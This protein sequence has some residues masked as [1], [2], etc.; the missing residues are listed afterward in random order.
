MRV[1][2]LMALPALASGC[3]YGLRTASNT[4]R[5]A[6]VYRVGKQEAP[7]GGAKGA[8]TQEPLPDYVEVAQ[9]EWMLRA[10]CL[11]TGADGKV[12]AIAGCTPS[13]QSPQSLWQEAEAEAAR[14]AYVE[15]SYSETRFVP[16]VQG[17]LEFTGPGAATQS[18]DL[19]PKVVLSAAD[20]EAKGEADVTKRG[21]N[22]GAEARFGN[23][24]IS[25]DMNYA[26]QYAQ[27]YTVSEILL[28]GHA[29]S[30]RLCEARRNGDITTVEYVDSMADLQD[31]ID[32]QIRYVL[33]TDRIATEGDNAAMLA[34][35]NKVADEVKEDGQQKSAEKAAEDEPNPAKAAELRTI[36][37][38]LY[39]G[40]KLTEKELSALGPTKVEAIQGLRAQD[41]VKLDVLDVEKQRLE[42]ALQ[43]DVAKEIDEEVMRSQRR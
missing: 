34:A 35:A 11:Q 26:E 33:A 3:A 40:E 16:K 2:I 24:D 39:N 36:G 5:A 23:I 8:P 12:T 30:F 13:E 21:A 19:S 42:Q 18:L 43:K 37:T 4:E 6:V 15:A 38:K 14:A 10:A 9:K 27:V 17:C 28:Y 20:A 29:M 7:Q 22:G 31:S 25:M 41:E 32:E 1:L